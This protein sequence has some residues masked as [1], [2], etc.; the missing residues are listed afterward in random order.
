MTRM[1]HR[2]LSTQSELQYQ[3]DPEPVFDYLL[4]HRA[5]TQSTVDVI[6]EE[7]KLADRNIKLLKHLEE[8]GN[9]AVELFI[10]ALRQSGQL[11]LASTLDVEHRIKPVQGKGILLDQIYIKTP[12][13][14]CNNHNSTCISF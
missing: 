12:F 6:R 11:H 10:N 14:K 7:E 13:I 5:L 3:L 9:S 2:E 4:Q 8:L 1:T